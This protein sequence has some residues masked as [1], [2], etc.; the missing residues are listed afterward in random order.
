MLHLHSETDMDDKHDQHPIHHLNHSDQHPPLCSF[1][2]VILNHHFLRHLDLSRNEVKLLPPTIKTLVSLTSLDVSRNRLRRLLPELGLL[3][4]LVH[5]NVSS[6]SMRGLKDLALEQLA[7]LTSFRL[8]D[9][10][11]MQS[12]GAYG[13]NHRELL[14]ELLPT[15]VECLLTEQRYPKGGGIHAS[16]RDATLLRS[17]LEPHCTGVLRRRLSLVFGDTTDPEETTREEAMLRLLSHY[18]RGVPVDNI[19][20]SSS[21]GS[22][23]GG[24][25]SSSR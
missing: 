17:Q 23:S 1:P 9:V 7:T 22:S 25:S 18:E 14:A 12:I 21:G 8:F 19:G 13:Q 6:N 3:F 10:R 20:G 15:T 5:L 11:R 24:S 4:N 16:D 2:T